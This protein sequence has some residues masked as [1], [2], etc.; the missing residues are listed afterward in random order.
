MKASRLQPE[1]LIAHARFVR[2]L[3][4]A[5]AFDV[6]DADDIAQEAWRAALEHPPRREGRIEGWLAALVRHGA[7]RSRRAESRRDARERAASRAEALPSAAALAER[8]ESLRRVV[9]AVLALPEPY[10]ATIVQRFYEDLPPREIARRAGIPVET[11][12]TRL[13]R[14]LARMRSELEARGDSDWRPALAALAGLEQPQAASA[15]SFWSG[16]TLMKIS[17]VIAAFAVLLAAS[18][19]WNSGALSEPQALDVTPAEQPR[20]ATLP[21][22][23]SVSAPRE[24]LAPASVPEVR[25]LA[26]QKSDP[27]PSGASS[28]KVTGV[29]VDLAGK[30]IAG[31]VVYLGHST[32]A[33]GDEPF[34]PFDA[35]RIK[36]GVETGDDG[37]FSLAGTGPEVTAWHPTYSPST[38]PAASAARIVLGPRSRLQ[39]RVVDAGDRPLVDEIVKLDQKSRGPE[40]KSDADG[41]V[42]F[43]G[44]EAGAHGL[45]IGGRLEQC[46]RLKAGEHAELEVVIGAPGAFELELRAPAPLSGEIEGM[47]V[48]LGR[49]FDGEE[50]EGEVGPGGTLPL[51]R[52]IEPGPYLF[53]TRDGWVA[54]FDAVEDRGV[55]ELG[56]AELVV[57][58]P[59]KLA[60]H[61][62]PADCD[63]FARL[64]VAR[65]PKRGRE[66]GEVHFRVVPGNYAIV[67]EAGILL[68][69]VEVPAAGVT[70]EIP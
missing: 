60:V 6:H 45:W 7:F 15:T 1:E 37:A 16:G 14:A 10:R 53:F 22:I 57:R 64:M 34:R 68:Q 52:A 26:A 20:V 19:L 11:V 4:R 35:K 49:V 18:F 55:V 62:L 9:E 38:V 42:M 29:V 41:K 58:T 24:E 28:A 23:E 17:T 21:A 43:V 69:T 13:K 2:G 67:G 70:V 36:N 56:A 39:V 30:P 65:L 12:N 40:Q 63:E 31:A 44:L 8:E 32:D 66:V 46:L 50:V 47:I 51:G 33:R 61:T 27:P 25:E 59:S 48:G 54:R 5:L 3:A